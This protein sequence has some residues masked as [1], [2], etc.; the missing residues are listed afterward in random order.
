[1][2]TKVATKRRASPAQSR[3]PAKKPGSADRLRALARR[4]RVVAEDTAMPEI[5]QELTH[6]ADALEDEADTL[7]RK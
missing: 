1:M 4:C 6:I 2:R 7:A 3:T 5:S